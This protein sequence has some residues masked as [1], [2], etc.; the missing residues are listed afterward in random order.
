[1]V[2]E[3]KE[4]GALLPQKR[5][6]PLMTVCSNPEKIPSFLDEIMKDDEQSEQNIVLQ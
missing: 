5:K 4:K 1:L 3:F 6:N 2:F